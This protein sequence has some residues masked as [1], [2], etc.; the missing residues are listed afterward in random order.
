MKIRKIPAIILAYVMATTLLSAEVVT[1][2]E[3]DAA[4]GLTTVQAEENLSE[5]IE[6]T[7]ESE[8]SVS[9]EDETTSDDSQ[10]ESESADDNTDAAED[11]N[12]DDKEVDETENSQD[13][14]TSG[15]DA[16]AK[17]DEIID[18]AEEEENPEDL[19]DTEAEDA[20]SED[21]LTEEDAKEEQEGPVVI[22]EELIVEQEESLADLLLNPMNSGLTPESGYEDFLEAT[23]EDPAYSYIFKG[24]IWIAGFDRNSLTYTGKAI[25]QTDL[26]VYDR[27]RLLKN[28]TDYKLTYKN[29]T[30][31]KGYTA[32][33]APY[34]T[35]TLKGNYVGARLFKY[36]ILPADISGASVST[37]EYA[38]SYNGKSQKYSPAV[39]F[40]GKTLKKDTHYTI[41]YSGNTKGDPNNITKID[42]VITGKGNFSKDTSI[43]GSYN[44]VGANYN[45]SKATVTVGNK[46]KYMGTEITEED[47]G[48]VVKINKKKVDPA[49]YQVHLDHFDG[50]GT[51][52]ITVSPSA[53]ALTTYAGSVKV[54]Y[55][56]VGGV[57]FKSK[58]IVNTEVWQPSFTYDKTTAAAG[59]VQE[60][61]DLLKDGDVS[62]VEGTDF[63]VTYSANKKVGT[64]KATFTGLGKY[65]GSFTKSFSIK[66]YNGAFHTE[67]EES[68]VYAK[69]G[70][71]LLVIV[72]DDN[73]AIL[74]QNVD[75]TIK[76]TGNDK[77]GTASYK[78]TGKGNYSKN[79]VASG[80]YNI[81]AGDLSECSIEV[82]EKAYSTK[83]KAYQSAPTIWDANNG[84]KLAAKTDYTLSYEI[85]D[86]ETEAFR[87]VGATEKPAVGSKIRVTAT[88]KNNYAGEES[89]ISAE[90][91]IFDAKK[92]ITKLF[93]KVDSQVYSGEEIIP[94]LS[95]AEGHGDIH[96]YLKKTDMAAK[97][98]EV[99]AADYVYVE[100]CSKNV[101]AGT[102]KVTLRAIG[103]YGGRASYKFTIKKKSAVL[104][105]I[106]SLK[107]K[108]SNVDLEIDGTYQLVPVINPTNADEVTFT[109]LSH[110]TSVVE[111][112]EEG[113]LTAV[114]VGITTVDVTAVDYSGKKLK[115][116]CYVF[117]GG[118]AK[119]PEMSEMLDVTDYG[120]IPDDGQDDS[121]A[122][123]DV[124]R[125]VAYGSSSEKGKSIWVPAG[126]YH[127]DPGTD[128][129]RME[130]IRCSNIH[131]YMDDNAYIQTMTTKNNGHYYTIWISD[132][133][134]VSIDG[135]HIIGDG[136]SHSKTK[137]G[138]EGHCIAI[139]GSNDVSISN[140][141]ISYATGD[142]IYI[143]SDN[144]NVPCKNVAITNCTVEYSRRNNLAIADGSYI[145]VANSKFNKA[146]SISNNSSFG[147]AADPESG[148]LFETNND[149]KPVSNI[150]LYN[151]SMSGNKRMAWG[152]I[153]PT[154]NVTF[155][156]CS[157]S[158][159]VHNRACNGL[160]LQ[161][162][163]IDGEFYETKD[164]AGTTRAKLINTKITKGHYVYD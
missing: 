91:R 14:I 112:D 128:G 94:T 107:F 15:D 138:I 113:L 77:V 137:P 151:C 6:E 41:T 143:G 101:K 157:M 122:F 7:E 80:T 48:L 131:I 125:A 52:Y 43:T 97:K 108:K 17:E 154:R 144:T 56:L 73:D 90:Y 115:A 34:V 5:D 13:D 57:D 10:D 60:T 55:K 82:I 53:E 87:P 39:K 24:D 100:S 16:D 12:A 126:V 158:G 70:P 114:N 78:V 2:A 120:A 104:N 162:C 135:G 123:N 118:D 145:T 71:K 9:S 30:N 129:H 59:F 109:Y 23:G 139:Y 88:G 25:K 148:V 83:A 142:G 106:S 69:G 136:A 44:I 130:V 3:A 49:N 117:V 58:A 86:N 35:V 134:N 153:R 102:A 75:Y 163:T 20:E 150:I 124:I 21:T 61:T 140:V 65:A 51:G 33:T 85:Y 127:L 68:I 156:K 119:R 164:F 11:T 74:K 22:S 95:D 132:V 19:V 36:S 116:T 18:E 31:A 146:K 105:K 133:E 26:K 32:S 152:I 149:K 4:A 161:D 121:Q 159:E 89:V 96:V 103:E 160:T 8:D 147:Y 98:N 92:A 64:A 62:L 46:V 29:N 28:G 155:I 72:K 141:H 54:S 84:K 45:F 76:F 111:V 1:A 47:L 50:V 99:N 93:I 40:N 79:T 63:K 81:I 37:A 66:Q 42:Y 27:D 38:M 110:N 67:A